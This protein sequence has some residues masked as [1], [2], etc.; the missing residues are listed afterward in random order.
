MMYW[1]IMSDDQ[2]QGGETDAWVFG[3]PLLL[4]IDFM[5]FLEQTGW[6]VRPRRGFCLDGFYGAKV[7]LATTLASK[8]LT[9]VNTC[10][11]SLHHYNYYS[12]PPNNI[13]S[14]HSTHLLA[15]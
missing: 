3:I 1:V 13:Q 2:W 5:V 12:T 15:P 10:T 9:R 11:F 14:H 4:V 7:V 6:K 8:G